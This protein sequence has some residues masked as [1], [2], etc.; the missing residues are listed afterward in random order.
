MINKIIHYCWFGKTEKPAIVQECIETWHKICP[1][2]EII[3]WNEDNFDINIC[4]YV[5]EAYQSKKW[6]FVSDYVRFYI[7][8]KMGGIYLDTDVEL[9]KPINKF[10]ESNF[11]G[12]E[13]ANSVATGLIMGCNPNNNLCKLMLDEYNS[14]KFIVNGKFNMRTVCH[15]VTD[16]FVKHGLV[17]Q[18]YTQ[19]VMDFTVYDSSYFNPYN[20]DTG[21]IEVKENTVSIHHY[22]GTWLNKKDKLRGKIYQLICRIFGKKTAEKIRKIVGRK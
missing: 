3:E 10:L 2:Y 16:I 14:D 22:A 21:V 20:M 12:F 19:K 8:D 15:R 1:D 13:S 5:K 18:D 17:L 11:V 6:A 9:I 4:D 7:L